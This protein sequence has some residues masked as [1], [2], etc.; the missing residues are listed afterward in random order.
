MTFHEQFIKRCFNLAQQGAGSVSPNPMVGAVL[1]HQNTIIGEG[2]HR[3]YGNAHAEVNAIQ[4]VPFHLRHLIPAATLYVS[5]EP[6]CF[7]GKTPACTNLI[8]EQRIPKVVVS[9]L[10]ATPNVNG[11]GIEI[12]RAHGVEVITGVLEVEG[13]QLV[14]PRAVFATQERPYVV[15]KLAK[16]QDGF[17]GKSEEQIWLTNAYVK[18]LVHKWRS[19]TDAILIGTNTAKIDNPQLTNRYYFGKNPQ[20]IVLDEHN[21][22][23]NHL[24]IKDQLIP[25]IVVTAASTV[26]EVPHE[27]LSYLQLPFNQTLLP[28]LLKSLHNRKVGILLVEGGAKLV[29]SFFDAGLWDEARIFE[30]SHQ[31][32][33][34]I[35]APN[36][37]ASVFETKYIG[38]DK[39]TVYMKE[40]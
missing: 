40:G 31:L 32:G 21:S 7:F 11:K 37:P 30:T 2:F 13:R 12:L 15:I 1:V 36:V 10:D 3:Q 33:D 24:A 29:Q 6:C 28:N 20:R 5:L 26:D 17:I 19:E 22:L 23:P 27:H 35:A 34:G 25:T 18:R 39:L 4:N 14:K 9:C 38:Q 16:S 8:L